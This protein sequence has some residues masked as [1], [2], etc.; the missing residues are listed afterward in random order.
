MSYVTKLGRLGVILSSVCGFHWVYDNVG[1]VAKV[2]GSSMYPALNPHEQPSDM[3]ILR[4][5]NGDYESIQRGDI[6]TVM[7]PYSTNDVFI[8][9]LVGLPGDVIESLHFHTAF[10]RIPPGHCWVEG[11]NHS[12][13]VDSNE[14]GPVPLGLVQSKAIGIL[15][16]AERRQYLKHGMSEET[17][18][19][20]HKWVGTQE[21][22]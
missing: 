14:F 20:V 15:W 10:V 21:E 5:I 7:P 13:S 22:G 1:Y 18:K 12:K 19:R 2:E 4:R 8:K 11:D 6:I 16:P 3:V 17:A 9:R